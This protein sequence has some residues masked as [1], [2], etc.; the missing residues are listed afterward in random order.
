MKGR[1]PKKFKLKDNRFRAAAIGMFLVGAA[2]VPLLL[3]VSIKLTFVVAALVILAPFI[4]M[5]YF[6]NKLDK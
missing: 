1:K 4:G 6:F 5:I 3:Q 2:S